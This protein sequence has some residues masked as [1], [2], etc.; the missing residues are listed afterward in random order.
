[1]RT[2]LK[3]PNNS[4]CASC[5][6]R[7]LALGVV[8]SVAVGLLHGNRQ[9]LAHYFVYPMLK[10]IFND[11]LYRV[12][13]VQDKSKWT[14]SEGTSLCTVHWAHLQV[15]TY[16]EKHNHVRVCKISSFRYP[17]HVPSSICTFNLYSSLNLQLI[18]KYDLQTL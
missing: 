9:I 10:F 2:G 14:A 5:S 17:C 18:F 12:T 6:S 7:R 4:Y 1:V 15:V 16:L 13:Y 8:R 11:I 3:T